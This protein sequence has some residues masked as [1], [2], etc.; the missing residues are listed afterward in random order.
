M[1]NTL[2]LTIT[3]TSTLLPDPKSLKIPASIASAQ[4]ATA[5]SLVKSLFHLVSKIAIAASEPD[6]IVTYG[7]LSVEPWA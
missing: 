1:G 6:P 3:Q 7:S 4:S 2:S 5:C